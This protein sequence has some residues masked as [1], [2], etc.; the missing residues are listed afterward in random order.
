MNVFRF[1]KNGK[2]LKT[3]LPDKVTFVE[4]G[5]DSLGLLKPK[6][7]KTVGFRKPLKDEYYLS[8]SMIKAYK[9]KNDMSSEYIIVVPE[10]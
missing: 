2:K 9:A 5:N 1:E 6:P 8:G 4:Y 3:K 10:I 7:F